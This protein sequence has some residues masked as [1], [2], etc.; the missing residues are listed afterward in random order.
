M[1]PASITEHLLR[2]A[3]NLSRHRLPPP[4]SHRLTEDR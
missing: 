3:K 4:V 2:Q 1:V